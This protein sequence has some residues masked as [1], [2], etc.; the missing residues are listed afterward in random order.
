VVIN[1]GENIKIVLSKTLVD[2]DGGGGGNGKILVDSEGGGG[3]N[4]ILKQIL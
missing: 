4:G 1:L 2:S 3:G